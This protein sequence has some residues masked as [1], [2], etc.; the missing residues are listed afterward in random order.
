MLKKGELFG[1]NSPGILRQE[2]PCVACKT[3]KVKCD[4]GSPCVRCERRSIPCT[5][6][7]N[8]DGRIRRYHKRSTAGCVCCKTRHVRCD[9]KRPICGNCTVRAEEVSTRDEIP[10]HMGLN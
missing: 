7:F 8:T 4:Y 9:E 1:S 3:S 10:L 6:A 5:Y 2:K